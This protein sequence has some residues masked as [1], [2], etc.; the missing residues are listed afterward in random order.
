MVKY[1]FTQTVMQFLCEDSI[2][3]RLQGAAIYNFKKISRGYARL[4][5]PSG[6]Q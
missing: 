3:T 4:S 2:K 5:D 1:Y 6:G